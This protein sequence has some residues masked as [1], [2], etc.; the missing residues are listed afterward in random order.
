MLPFVFH[1][2]FLGQKALAMCARGCCVVYDMSTSLEGAVQC[3][4][5]CANVPLSV[6]I[7]LF[8]AMF[9]HDSDTFIF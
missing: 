5:L 4:A 6:R 2:S 8:H 1:F 9:D 7:N 3:N